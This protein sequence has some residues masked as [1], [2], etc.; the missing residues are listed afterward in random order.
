M[1]YLTS[2]GNLTVGR[3]SYGNPKILGSLPVTIGS[4]CSIADGVIINA[5]VDHRLDW[6]T[7]YPFTSKHLQ[8]QWGYAKEGHP[9][10]KGPV[11]IRSAVW[12]GCN[13]L[14]MS[15]VKI[16]HGAIIGAGS[17]V[18]R[19]VR[20]YSKTAGNP[21]RHISW[22]ANYAARELLLEMRW[23]EWPDHLIKQ[24]VPFLTS[25]NLGN[26]ETFY[27]ENQEEI[28]RGRVSGKCLTESLSDD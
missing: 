14:I 5:G 27:Y 2:K 22:T 9:T 24:A 23:W 10:G 7:T 16:G 26:L 4:F 19:D 25:S 18:T 28:S 12:I 1:Q 11:I 13:V 3:W 20:S 15:G 6:I 8:G 17:V 21:A